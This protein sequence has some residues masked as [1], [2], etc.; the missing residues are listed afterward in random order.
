MRAIVC[1]KQVPDTT[2]VKINPETNTL[3]REGVASIVNPFDTYAIEEALRLKEQ[4]GG[5]VTVLSMG[6]AQAKEA[7]KEAVAMG[8]DEAV[9]LSD[10]AFAGSDTWATAYTLA[11]AIRRLGEFDVILCGKQA[12][13][14]DTGQV[15]PGIARQL[16]IP[17]LTYICRIQEFDPATKRVRVER[18]LE[19]GRE[20]VTCTLPV[21]LTVVKDINQPR[22]PTF[23]GIRRATRMEI[24]TW[25][26]A[27]LATANAD[28]LGLKG[29]PTQVV[30]IFNP[31]ARGGTV[32]LF[33]ADTPSD[34]AAQLAERLLADKVI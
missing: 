34:G 8:A 17:Q 23:T 11:Q 5:T 30:R 28:Y 7:L 3:I 31:P 21:L 29:S 27:E 19:E 15:G 14:G 25:G 20:V 10:R 2:E 12:I 22:Y 18:L 16:Q 33:T 32:T 1:I 4:H 6:P 26:A 13:D 24:P 9:L